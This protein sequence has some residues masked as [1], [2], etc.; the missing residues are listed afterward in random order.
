MFN[1]KEKYIKKKL[2][3]EENIEFSKKDKDEIFDKI[4]NEL[5]LDLVSK[6][7]NIRKSLNLKIIYATVCSL[8]ICVLGYVGYELFGKKDFDTPNYKGKDVESL[9]LDEGDYCLGFSSDLSEEEIYI[10][11]FKYNYKFDL[12]NSNIIIAYIIVYNFFPSIIINNDLN[13]PIYINL[14][15]KCDSIVDLYNSTYQTEFDVESLNGDNSGLLFKIYDNEIEFYTI[16][17]KKRLSLFVEY[18]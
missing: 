14:L 18:N 16:K 1:K 9:N 3:N 11:C 15:M 12:T 4:Q 8:V 2:L 13:N 6:K 5:N 7:K 10:L 17:N